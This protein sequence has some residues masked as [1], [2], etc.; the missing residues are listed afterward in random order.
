M[1][2]AKRLVFLGC[3]CLAAASAC[4]K[5]ALVNPLD[6]RKLDA[7]LKPVVDQIVPANNR[8]ALE[9]Y[10]R[11]AAQPGNLFCSPQ[12]ISTA[13]AMTYAGA[14]GDTRAEMASVFHFPLAQDS[15]HAAF[16]A[17]LSSLDRGAALG[18]Y[19]LSLANRL[20][21]QRGFPFLAPFLDITGIHYRAEL[22]TLDFH[23]HPSEARDTINTWVGEKT[24]GK[25]PELM[26]RSAVTS[27][28]RLV[29]TSAIYFK[30]QWQT[31]FDPN[32]TASGPFHVAPGVDRMVPTMRGELACRTGHGPGVRLLELPYK[33]L[34]LSM[35][36]LLPDSVFGLAELES[37][38]IADD[39]DTWLATLSDRK[40]PVRLPRFTVESSFSL[41]ETLAAMGMPSAFQAFQ[42]DFSGMDGA[43]D[44]FIAAAVHKAFVNV[45]EEG[46]EAAAATGISI[47]VTSLPVDNFYVDHPFVFLIRDNVTGSLLFVGR[48]VEPPA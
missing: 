19:E 12:N 7:S 9:L 29:L 36:I 4:G 48:I 5:D 1:K 20:W 41:V 33:G 14:A 3:L 24:R 27:D 26:P 46:T 17:V 31:K 38:L 15:I 44:L 34:D 6:V 11:L 28:T 32:L 43:R 22:Q 39:L 25:I 16:G 37:R 13:F 2:S 45:N 10:R 21:G 23:A 8:F 18:G 40:L 30:G 47:G 35:V 42:A